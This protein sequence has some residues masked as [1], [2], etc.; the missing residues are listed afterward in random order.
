MYDGFPVVGCVVGIEFIV[1]CGDDL[2]LDVGDNITA[3]LPPIVI[4]TGGDIVGI[5][6]LLL[7]ICKLF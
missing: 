7:P 5:L 2:R 6:L 4:F 1:F 3:S